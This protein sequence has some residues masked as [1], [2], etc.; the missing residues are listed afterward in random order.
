MGYL[1][2]FL[3]PHLLRLSRSFPVI[4]LTGARQVGKTTLLQ[5][6]AGET[7]PPMRYVSL[8]D[9][10]QRT[11]AQEDPGLFLERLGRP[12]IIDEIQ[13]APGLL[14]RIKPLVDQAGLGGQYWLSGSQQFGL[15][16]HVSE[17]LAGR[18]AVV[19]LHGL[20][21]AEERRAPDPGLPFRPD[22]LAAQT[23]AATPTDRGEG[24][25]L[26]VYGRI[27]RGSFPR[28][29]QPEAP[30]L[31]DFY[32]SY[33][34]TYL[35]RDV[36]AQLSVSDLAAFR[37]F[38][39]LCAARVSQLLNLSDLARDAGVSVSTAK[40]WLTALEATFQVMLLRPHFANLTKRQTKT[41]KLYFMDTGLAC[42]LTGWRSAETAALGAMAGPLLECHVV[43]EVLKSYRHRGL[44]APLYFWRDKQNHEVDLLIA[45]DGQLFPVEVKR[46]ASPARTDLRGVDAMLRAGCALGPT[47]LVCLVPEPFGLAPGVTAVPVTSLA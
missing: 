31:D 42:Y 2:R 3:E 14:E 46:T 12:A 29:A 26:A 11:M 41:P 9:Y 38:L 10:A 37:T 20:A 6:L 33:L 28:F 47:A 35:E 23:T 30:P 15:M 18:V 19:D 4:L 34:Q 5:H 32:S 36:R 13:N 7:D 45:E 27:V 1:P 21:W 39:R 24:D 44:Q 17:S 16:K 8:D 43:I 25:L 40:R 22:R